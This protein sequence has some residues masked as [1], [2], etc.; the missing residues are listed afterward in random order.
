[1][2]KALRQAVDE[3]RLAQGE[4]KKPVA[5]GD[6]HR[7][8]FHHMLGAKKPL[9]AAFNLGPYPVGGD[10]STIWSSFSSYYTSEV[11]TIAGPAFRFIADLSN[12]DNCWGMLVPGQSGHPASPHYGDG[13][14]PWLNGSYHPMLFQRSAV[15]KNLTAQLDLTPE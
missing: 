14:Q 12:L 1:M 9:D 8:T 13:I 5:W 3:L 2:K 7:L 4:K 15:E 10:G 6:L 11:G